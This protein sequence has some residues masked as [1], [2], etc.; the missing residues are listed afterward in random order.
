M[1]HLGIEAYRTDSGNLTEEDIGLFWAFPVADYS[2]TENRR[3]EVGLVRKNVSSTSVTYTAGVATEIQEISVA[4]SSTTELRITLDPDQPKV[5]Q[6]F[7]VDKLGFLSVK[8]VEEVVEEDTT[9]GDDATTD[10]AAEETTEDPAAADET[11]L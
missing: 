3:W 1:Y 10:P 11:L 9:G 2:E 7:V 5:E 6:D 4:N 8:E